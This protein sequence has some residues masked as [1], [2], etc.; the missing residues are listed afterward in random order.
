M[1]RQTIFEYLRKAQELQCK[2]FKAGISYSVYVSQFNYQYDDGKD[3]TSLEI[4]I[5]M[6]QGERNIT[7]HVSDYMNTKWCDKNL[8]SFIAEV[9]N[10]LGIQL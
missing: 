8:V 4:S 5:I 9:N 2:L 10:R 3:G 6:P 1:E 7:W